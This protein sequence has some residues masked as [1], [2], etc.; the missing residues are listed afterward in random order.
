MTS[1][2][3][4]ICDR[5][6]GLEIDMIGFDVDPD[7][8]NVC[9]TKCRSCRK[10]ITFEATQEEECCDHRYVGEDLYRAEADSGQHDE[11]DE[12]DEG[13]TTLN[14]KLSVLVNTYRATVRQ[15]KFWSWH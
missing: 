5:G 7:R 2:T 9:V 4:N 1:E 13:Q 12:F 6:V 3:C 11:P 15:F 8:G 14:K 10:T